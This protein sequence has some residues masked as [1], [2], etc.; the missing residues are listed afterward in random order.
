MEPLL[1]KDKKVTSYI[2]KKK[3]VLLLLRSLCHAQGTPL[4]SDSVWTLDFW[5][6]TVLLNK[7]NKWIAL[8][9]FSWF[10]NKKNT[11]IFFLVFFS[12]FKSCGFTFFWGFLYILFCIFIIIFIFLIFLKYFQIL[13][14]QKFF[15]IGF[16]ITWFPSGYKSLPKPTTNAQW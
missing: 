14:L 1:G 16:F 13:L 7:Q 11:I 9:S 12:L 8:I 6:R 10:K 5:S 2:K 15:F 4:D 3:I